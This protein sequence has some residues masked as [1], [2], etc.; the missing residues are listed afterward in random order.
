MSNQIIFRKGIK[1]TEQFKTAILQDDG[2]VFLFTKSKKQLHPRPAAFSKDD[3]YEIIAAIEEIED[4]E[5][6]VDQPCYDCGSEIPKH[7]TPSCDLTQPF[8][9]KDLPEKPGTQ[10]W[11]K[12]KTIATEYTPKQIKKMMEGK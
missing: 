5:N 3:L 6:S 4:S 11:D 1:S 2:S 8:D 7:H 12:P 10:H 9:H